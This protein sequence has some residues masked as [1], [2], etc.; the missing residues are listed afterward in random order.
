MTL[1]LHVCFLQ[2]MCFCWLGWLPATKH[3]AEMK[4]HFGLGTKIM[5]LGFWKRSVI[6]GF[7]KNHAKPS[8]LSESAVC[9]PPLNH[10]NH[11]FWYFLALQ[12]LR[13]SHIEMMALRWI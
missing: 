4:C 10:D 5:W 2:M 13:S 6:F 11:H 7:T 3:V 12:L 1:G 9:D 8:L